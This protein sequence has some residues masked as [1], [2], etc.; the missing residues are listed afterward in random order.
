MIEHGVVWRRWEQ[1][2]SEYWN[3]NL[4][5]AEYCRQH[6]LRIRA[7]RKWI[8]RLRPEMAEKSVM[9]DIVKLEPPSRG[10]D[11][12]I[13][14]ELGTIRVRLDRVLSLLEVR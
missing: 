9:L 8:K 2:L 3:S 11:S 10:D 7:A 5:V 14:L 1:A 12:G 6:D 13:S 4:T